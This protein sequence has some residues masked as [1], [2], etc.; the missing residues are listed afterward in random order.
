ME[1]F[2][3]KRPSKHDAASSKHDSE[4][5]DHDDD[6]DDDD[7]PYSHLVKSVRSDTGLEIGVHVNWPQLE[8][9][10]LLS[11]CLPE[12]NIAPI[13]HGSQ[14]AGT[15]VWQA[16]MVALEYLL[17]LS[18]TQDGMIMEQVQDATEPQGKDGDS[19]E[20]P[21]ITADTCLLELGAGLAAPSLILRALR[22]CTIV[23]TDVE[24]LVSQLQ[25]NIEANKALL[26]LNKVDDDNKSEDAY[27]CS[28]MAIQACE[29]DWS[30]VGVHDML[31]RLSGSHNKNITTINPPDPPRFDVIFNCDCLFEP[32]YGPSNNL[33]ECQEAL[34]EAF[35]QSLMLTVCERRNHD[36]IDKYL[37]A[38]RE[39]PF[40]ERVEQIRPKTFECPMEVELYRIYGIAS[41][42]CKQ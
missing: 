32:L 34:L 33:V 38:L 5:D 23:M 17:S 21:F 25:E 22:Q 19:V 20:T 10:L 28:D 9:P 15:R 39:S 35:P 8:Q 40:V 26:H 3:T 36:G 24:S 6:N 18:V 27:T 4:S 29:L 12:E 13:F 41:S 2:H 31:A 16:S 14:W 30:R 11:T 42:G 7:D 37:T 1:F